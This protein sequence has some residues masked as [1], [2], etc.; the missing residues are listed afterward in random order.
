MRVGRPRCTACAGADRVLD[1]DEEVRAGRVEDTAGPLGAAAAGA[2]ADRVVDRGDFHA[3]VRQVVPVGAVVEAVPEIVATLQRTRA[4]RTLAILMEREGDPVEQ[5]V[6]AA[7]EVKAD[8][9]VM[10]PGGAGVTT[11]T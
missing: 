4:R 3:A 5:I 1:A 6:A 9:V 8:L 2:R 11:G 10:P 7:A